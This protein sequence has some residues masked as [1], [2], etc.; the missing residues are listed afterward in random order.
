MLVLPATVSSNLR[1]A[2]VSIFG[3]VAMAWTAAASAQ[4]PPGLWASAE[5]NVLGIATGDGTLQANLQDLPEVHGLAVDQTHGNLWVDSG[6]NLLAY[7]GSGH[8]LSTQ[9]LPNAIADGADDQASCNMVVDGDAG[10]VWLAHHHVLYRFSSSGTLLSAVDMHHDI[11]CLTLDGT[12]SQVWAAVNHSLQVFDA[13]GNRIA[14]VALPRDASA[15]AYDGDLDQV[16]VAAGRLLS[17][18]TPSGNA[19]FSTGLAASLGAF[20]TPDGQGG[21]W[22]AGDHALA[23]FDSSGNLAFSFTPFADQPSDADGGNQIQA[24]VADP[25]SHAVWVANRRLIR[26]YSTDSSMQQ[27][28]DTDTFL[29]D[30]RH[31]DDGIRLALRT[32]IPP[33]VTILAPTDGEAFNFSYFVAGSLEV[34]PPLLLSF[35]PDVDPASIRVTANGQ[36][37][38]VSCSIDAGTTGASCIG[39]V[40]SEQA[41]A[42]Q[43]NGGLPLC[44]TFTITV[45]VANSSGLVSQPATVTILICQSV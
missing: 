33:T 38:P 12:R 27:T 17:R 4:T 34:Y 10:N 18:Y 45:T 5:D 32:A 25:A 39:Y 11:G 28:V 3:L 44:P 24:M 6:S 1:L 36:D 9:P 42:I 8:L 41:S 20:I 13:A 22:V 43:A 40:S 31:D 30:G 14:S 35:G 15:I 2:L 29:G 37:N 26:R 16:W 21:A 7:D 19:V 23:Y